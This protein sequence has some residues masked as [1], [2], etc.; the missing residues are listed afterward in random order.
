MNAPQNERG[1]NRHPRVLIYFLS[2]HGH[3]ALVVCHDGRPR[4]LL[5]S[6]SYADHIGTSSEDAVQGAGRGMS[7]CRMQ[8]HSQL[9]DV[10]VPPR[11]ESSGEDHTP[12]DPPL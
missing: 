3:L 8:E 4:R 9:Q 11:Q 10:Q 1:T 7:R 12:R 6:R 2:T 5:G